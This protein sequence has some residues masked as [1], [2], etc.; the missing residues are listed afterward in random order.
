LLSHSHP[1]LEGA[2][3]VV[4]ADAARRYVDCTDSVCRLLGYERSEILVRTID[5]LSFVAAEVPKLF[6]EYLQRGRM[7]GE[8]VLKHKTGT[9]I[10]IRFRAFVFGD[11]CAA[12]TWELISDWRELYL[13]A[14]VEIDPVKLKSRVEMAMQAVQQRMREVK[15]GEIDLPNVRPEEQSLR[16]ALSALH[17]LMRS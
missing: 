1:E 15:T 11:G 9:P 2:E 12:A 17:S 4:F 16:D 5:D 6:A 10:P 8:Y 7:K 14:L 13:A 3:Y